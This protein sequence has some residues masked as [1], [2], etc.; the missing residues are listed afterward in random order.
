MFSN[1]CDRATAASEQEYQIYHAAEQFMYES[2]DRLIARIT[3]GV[4]EEETV[5]L[6]TSDHGAKATGHKVHQGQILADAGLTVFK[7]AKAQG[8]HDAGE[9]AV[10]GGLAKV[11]VG[12]SGDLAAKF[13][14]FGE[15]DWSKTKAIVQRACHVFINMKGRN[16]NG[17][18]DPKDYEGVQDE[19]V[20]ALHNYTDPETGKKPITLALKREDAKMIFMGGEYTGDVVYAID[21]RF[22]GQHC[23]ILGTETHGEIGNLRSLFMMS[24]P[25][26]EEGRGP[27]ADHLAAGRGA[28]PLLSGGSAG[29][30]AVR[31][32]DRLPGARGPQPEAQR[33]QRPQ[34]PLRED[35]Q[36]PRP[37]ADV[38]A[39]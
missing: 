31:G 20:A 23:G 30:R 7:P 27:G 16:P 3:S 25:G 32:R 6:L 26:E 33:V 15:I 9:E 10:V 21:S 2:L 39:G 17:I 18:V 37:R 28:H 35:A 19:I 36:V 34:A 38:L 29:A 24:G 14:E 1:L 4:D 22:Y 5:I 11:K 13:K 8:A 12:S